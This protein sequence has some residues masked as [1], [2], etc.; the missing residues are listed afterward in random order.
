M[1]TRSEL[2]KDLVR[3][4]NEIEHTDILTITAFMDD[5]A[6]AAHRMRYLKTSKAATEVTFLSCGERGFYAEAGR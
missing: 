4:Q 5:D 1:M 2:M 3:L 6:V